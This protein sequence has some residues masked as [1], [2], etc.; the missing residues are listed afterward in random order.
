[1]TPKEEFENAL[2]QLLRDQE[3]FLDIERKIIQNLPL[4]EEKR[5]EMAENYNSFVKNVHQF[6]EKWA[7]KDMTKLTT[8]IVGGGDYGSGGGK[9]NVMQEKE[10]KDDISKVCDG[11]GDATTNLVPKSTNLVITRRDY[12]A[13]AALQGL[14]AT[15]IKHHLNHDEV[16]TLAR[17]YADSLIEELDKDE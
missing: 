12:F 16:V 4:S 2:I 17:E 3:D 7:P 15:P 9:S 6:N 8:K 11:L 14:L 5:N 1:M 13:A 10:P